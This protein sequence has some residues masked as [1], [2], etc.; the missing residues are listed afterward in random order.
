MEPV[1]YNAIMKHAEQCA[2]DEACG[3]IIVHSGKEIYWPCRNLS[4]DREFLLHP[5]DY[6][7]AEDHGEVTVIV[8]SHVNAPALPSDA[9]RRG[10]EESGLPWV[11]VAYPGGHVARLAPSGWKAPLVGRQFH[12]GILD[13]FTLVRDY[14]KE[15]YN[16]DMMD[17]PRSPGW[18]ERGEDLFTKNCE[19]RGFH[20]VSGEP[21]VGDLLLFQIKYP[22]PHHI[23]VY[24]GDGFFL[25]HANN[26]LSSKDR[27][28]GLWRMATT[29]IL[30]HEALA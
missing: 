7:D 19:T 18:E 23:G 13:C 2:P 12:Y 27:W 17:T 10:C 21:R 25:H 14:Y 22:V 16:I 30:R 9:D 20:I 8:H 3:V 28:A 4:S 11:I 24:T 29:H 15:I 1:V 26:R 5:V 6:A